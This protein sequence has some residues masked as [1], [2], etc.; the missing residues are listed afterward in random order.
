MTKAL[1]I[2]AGI[3]GLASAISIKDVCS[4]VYIAEKS[5][6]IT[7]VGAG[8]QLGPNA[9]RILMEWGLKSAL[10]QC[11]FE[12][13]SVQVLSAV[14]GQELAKMNLG[15]SFRDKYSAPYL[16]LHR[17]DLHHLLYAHA[18]QSSGVTVLLGHEAQD[19]ELSDQGVKAGFKDPGALSPVQVNSLECDFAV[20]AD[21]V[22][23]QLKSLLKDRAAEQRFEVSVAQKKLQPL[24]G[25]SFSGDLA[26]RSL[27]KQENLP[28]SLRSNSVRVW[29]APYMHMVQYPIRGGEYL[30]N[31]LFLDA[32][33]FR[34]R[35]L[36]DSDQLN[37]QSW[38]LD[39]DPAQVKLFLNEV[40]SRY[41][42]AIQNSVQGLDWSVWPMMF[43]Q[44][45]STPDQMGTGRL[46]LLGDAAHPMLPY[47]AQGAGMAIEDADELGR[48]FR[49]RG[50]QRP[51][52]VIAEYAN[53]R[54][55]RN[56]AVQQ[57][58]IRNQKIFH[59][60]GLVAFAR[61]QSLRLLGAAAMDMP[62]L[63]G[64]KRSD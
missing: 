56:A 45:I 24:A 63:Y 26:Y 20:G 50:T 48:Q 38:N 13:Q 44:P 42:S 29:L 40:L 9:T 34:L 53:R 51:E 7:D 28:S 1:I 37:S 3:G 31:V 41:C 17:A 12:P 6:H 36:N 59:S 49:A 4:S 14:T 33:H 60:R 10:S 30:N 23:S 25:A 16:T 21:G 22:W 11:A 8:I 62:W 18:L 27:A 55:A 58:A 5:P 2:G 64:Y 47:L 19:L 39:I 46:A 15:L 57:R 54:W 43:A 35:V 61:D 52:L 32:Q